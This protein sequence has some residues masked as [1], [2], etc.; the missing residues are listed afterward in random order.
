MISAVLS[1]ERLVLY[2]SSKVKH[3]RKEISHVRVNIRI[4]ISLGTRS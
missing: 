1:K 2:D 3:E 4:N